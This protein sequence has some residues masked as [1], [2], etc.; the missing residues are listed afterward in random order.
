MTTT[1]KTYMARQGQVEQ[2]WH[3]VDA[4]DQVLGRL[5]ADLARVLQ[6]KHK[7]EYTPHV[8][9]GDFVVVVN[10]DKLR[11]TGANKPA[12]KVFKRYSG[13]PGGQKEIPHAVMMERHPTRVLE[14]AVRRMLPKNRLGAAMLKKLKLFTGPDHNH[15]AQQPQPMELNR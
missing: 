14:E 9:C 11:V 1:T 5:A 15:Q 10:V 2:A 12:Q 3:L 13:Y 4:T 6:G 7:P 8:D